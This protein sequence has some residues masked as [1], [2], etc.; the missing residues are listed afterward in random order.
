MAFMLLITPLVYGQTFNSGSDGSDGALDFTG[1]PAGTTIDFDPTTFTPPLDPDGDSIYHFTTI[2]V[3]SDVTIKFRAVKV[4]LAPIHWLATGAV[5]IDGTLDLDG[6]D[7]HAIN[8]ARSLSRPGPGGFHGGFGAR[9]P[10]LPLQLG[11]GPGGGCINA[12]G[13]GH[14]TAG[15][16]GSCPDS[17]YG[18]SFLLPLIGGSGGSGGGSS[19]LNGGGGGA[20]GGA[21]LIASSVSIAVDGSILAKGGDAGSNSGGVSGAG[22]GGAI[23]LVAP[24]ISGAGR[25]DVSAGGNLSFGFTFG[26]VGRGRLEALQ[27]TFTGN[28]TGDIRRATL[29]PNPLVFPTMAAPGIRVVSVGGVVAPSNPAGSFNPVDV[30]INSSQQVDIV[31]EGKNIPVGTTVTV[32]V[33]NETEGLVVVESGPLT[34]TEALSNATATATVP[35]GFN[36]IFTDVKF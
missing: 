27:D 29:L 7:G 19:S 17:T 12:R 16:A 26:G 15:G 31:L 9:I 21:I 18:N 34:G 2:T 5:V 11:F 25:L 22:S 13:A 3:P 10:N 1:T 36:Q 24:S 8:E 28:T 23:R 4:G 6:E 33:V 32:T 14:A 30:N 20:G 35:A